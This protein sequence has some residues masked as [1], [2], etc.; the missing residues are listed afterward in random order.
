MTV[1][2]SIKC[3]VIVASLVP[4][5]ALIAHAQDRA[6][7]TSERQLVLL[8][9]DALASFDRGS[10]L[11]QTAP[12]EALDA[13]QRARD[14]FQAV[15]DAGIDNGRL[16]CNL[17]NTHLRLG[18]I[19]EA[20]AEYR[21]AERLTPNDERLIP[22]LQFARSLTRD[23]IEPSGKRT[24]LRTVFFWHY[25]WPLRAR[26]IATMIGYEL[27]WLLLAVMV[28]SHRVGLRYVTL[29]LLALWV[30]LGVSVVID[31]SSRSEPTEGVLVVNDVVVRKGNGESYDPQFDQS[32]HEGVEFGLLE[33]RGGWIRIE[34]AD[35]N[36]GWVREREVEL[37]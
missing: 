26:G 2:R 23:R 29:A 35:G 17:G 33:R 21:R 25:S 34:L 3:V 32:L 11:L 24:F 22:N 19:G 12:D 15:V 13:F 20:I 10:M 1:R 28:L 36:E 6:P 37:F 7:D 5:S 18:E 30:T 16:Y 31:L 14:G 8:L 9:S 27:F 4:A